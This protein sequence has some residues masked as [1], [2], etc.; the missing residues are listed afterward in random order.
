MYKKRIPFRNKNERMVN[1][2]K[3]T[4]ISLFLA[5]VMMLSVMPA[6]IAETDDAP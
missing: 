4:L 1:L 2:M 6:C 5:V 3:K